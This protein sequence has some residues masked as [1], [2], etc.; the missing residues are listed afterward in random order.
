MTMLDRPVEA[1]KAIIPVLRKSL[2]ASIATDAYPCW[3]S[4]GAQGRL[5]AVMLEAVGRSDRLMR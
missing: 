4:V 3:I 2:F 1:P 5:L